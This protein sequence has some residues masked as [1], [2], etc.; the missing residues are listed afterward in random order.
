MR[1]ITLPVSTPKKTLSGDLLKKTVRKALAADTLQTFDAA[2]RPGQ[3]PAGA[4]TDAGTNGKS[5]RLTPAQQKDAD[6]VA[7]LSPDFPKQSWDSMSYKAQ[8]QAMK[9]SELT[10]Q[11]QW[12]LLN[13]SAPLSVLDA[14]NRE[15]YRPV[16][17]TGADKDPEILTNPSK[18]PYLQNAES[19][20]ELD[21]SKGFP[22]AST[23]KKP[24]GRRD[25]LK[26]ITEYPA[27]AH[28]VDVGRVTPE[29]LTILSDAQYELA[30]LKVKGHPTQQEIDDILAD[31]CTKMLTDENKPVND[32]GD[33]QSYVPAY[34]DA[35]NGFFHRLRIE[36]EA[37]GDEFQKRLI[38]RKNIY[39]LIDTFDLYEPAKFYLDFAKDNLET[40][41]M[42]LRNA[43]TWKNLITQYSPEALPLNGSQYLFIYNGMLLSVEDLGNI[44]YGYR[45]SAM[46]FMR[47][48]LFIGTDIANFVKYIQNVS[49]QSSEQSAPPIGDD[50]HDKASIDFGIQL[51]KDGK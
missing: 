38:A 35:I 34:T 7:K 51:Y 19:D 24:I 31:A 32:K 8:L 22:D 21:I 39:G 23:P 48:D 33:K 44:A 6:V 3:I 36:G 43:G 41:A 17:T 26:F 5:S 18:T 47:L 20:G 27:I 49:K 45:G 4:E 50:P 25:T 15:R 12:Q 10:E 2:D 1:K 29:Q 46:G 30:A 9:F 40:G 14:A 11:E 37:K 42:N 16:T 28:F 13:P